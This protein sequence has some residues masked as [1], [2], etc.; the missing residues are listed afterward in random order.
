M[1]L[2]QGFTLQDR[3]YRLELIKGKSSPL[4]KLRSKGFA[5]F[6]QVNKVDNTADDLL[7]KRMASNNLMDYKFEDRKRRASNYIK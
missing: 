7:S 4:G 2:E 6:S 3:S 5:E 1:D